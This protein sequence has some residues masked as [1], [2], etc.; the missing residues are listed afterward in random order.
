MTIDALGGGTAL[1]STLAG[2]TGSGRDRTRAQPPESIEKGQE[3]IEAT[4]E[5]PENASR[6]EDA[7]RPENG[8]K[9]EQAAE[10]RSLDDI[11]EAAAENAREAA[12][13]RL[14]ILYDQDIDLFISRRVDPES[15]E[16]VRQFPYEEQL[17]RARIFAEQNR[18]DT[19]QRL[20]LSV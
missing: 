9:T 18:E 19:D 11:V 17:E 16:V 3:P 7:S 14:S 6:P 10:S 12:A 15:G 20:D 5:P 1:T 13:T 2:L 4:I 8:L